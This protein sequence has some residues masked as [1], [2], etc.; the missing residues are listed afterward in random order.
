MDTITPSVLQ[1]AATRLYAVTE[2]ARFK[3][4]HTVTITLNGEHGGADLTI[5]GFTGNDV[6]L[7]NEQTITVPLS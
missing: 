6:S 4:V 7:Y 3:Y 1:D 2:F 5:K